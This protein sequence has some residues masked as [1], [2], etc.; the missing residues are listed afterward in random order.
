VPRRHRSVDLFLADLG[1]AFM[2]WRHGP[3]LKAV[4]SKGNDWIGGTG[5]LVSSG[6]CDC[7]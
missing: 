1:F 7:R 6:G 3:K 5:A 4:P 2:V